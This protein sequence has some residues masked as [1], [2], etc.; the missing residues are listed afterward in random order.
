MGDDMEKTSV[1]LPRGT[2]DD[3][4]A[5]AKKRGVF[6]SQIMRNAILEEIKKAKEEGEI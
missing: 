1:Q 2:K 4:T 3:V 5:L 6:P